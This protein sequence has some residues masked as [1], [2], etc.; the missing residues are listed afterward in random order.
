M[1]GVPGTTSTGTQG[2]V[3]EFDFEVEMWDDTPFTDGP[4]STLTKPTNPGA[5][6]QKPPT[7]PFNPDEDQDM[8]D[9]AYELQVQAKP[10]ENTAPPGIPPAP[11]DDDDWDDMYA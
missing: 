5:N 7:P 11:V 8:W 2:G 9:L 4:T 1:D 10:N 3:D 6:P